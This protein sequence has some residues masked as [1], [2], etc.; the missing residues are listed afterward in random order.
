MEA[1]QVAKATGH[2]V[3]VLWTRE[4]D[5]Q[6]DFYRPAS[7]HRR[8]GAVDSNGKLAAWKHFQTSTSISAWWDPPAR[9]KPEKSEFAA[10]GFIP[11]ATPNYR[12]EY[13]LAQS[14]VPRAWWRS[15]ESSSS[16][17]VVE[18]F[19]D[20]LAAAA[21]GDPLGFSLCFMGGARKGP[22]FFSQ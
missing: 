20:E 14:G 1:A 21:G 18:S 7:Y 9:A 17:F 19:V 3:Q 15:V 22:A 4:D 8:S 5:M 12:I 16:G 11:Y 6:H 10:A 2:P 13:A